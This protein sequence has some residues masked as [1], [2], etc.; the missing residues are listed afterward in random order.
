[1]SLFKNAIPAKCLF[2]LAA[3]ALAACG[4]EADNTAD[5]AQA[6]GDEITITET[7]GTKIDTKSWLASDIEVIEYVDEADT[8]TLLVIARGREGVTIEDIPLSRPLESGI[9]HRDMIET[10]SWLASDAELYTYTPKSAPDCP[11]MFARSRDTIDATVL[12]C[13]PSL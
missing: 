11:I 7:G 9:Q 5:T 4:G 10:S 3:T 2:L 1:M 8:S 6:K 12:P 13:K